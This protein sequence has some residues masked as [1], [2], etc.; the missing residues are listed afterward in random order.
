M[1]TV[2]DVTTFID[3][4]VLHSKL[5]DSASD[6]VK[7]KAVNQA[8]NTLVKYL[9]DV[10]K[11]VESL[12]VD[13][14][15]EQVLWLLKMDDS[16]QR[17]EMGAMMITVDG[18]QIQLKDMDR[19]ISPKLL[20]LHGKDGIRQRRVG[21]YSESNGFRVGQQYPPSHYRKIGRLF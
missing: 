18:I 10:Y 11:D 19:T 13:E 3:G 15:A 12:P 1:I 9:S 17:A 8:V 21:S 20:A 16:M 7:Q 4:N 14:V 2:S 5:Y 6:A